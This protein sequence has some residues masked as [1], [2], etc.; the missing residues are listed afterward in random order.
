M[1]RNKTEPLREDWTL[2]TFI[3]GNY[4]MADLRT[5]EGRWAARV[6]AF[7]LAKNRK[8]GLATEI[9]NLVGREEKEGK[10]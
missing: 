4:F 3:K 2:D 5:E 9:L 8:S 6:C 7:V 1:S 10:A